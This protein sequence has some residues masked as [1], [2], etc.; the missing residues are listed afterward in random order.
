VSLYGRRRDRL[1]GAFALEP[2][3][4]DGKILINLDSED[5]GELFIG[6]AGGIDTVAISLSKPAKYLLVSSRSK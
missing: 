6:C 3:F 5:E 4:F 1:T 2:G